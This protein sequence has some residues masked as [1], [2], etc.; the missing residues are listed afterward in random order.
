MDM[1]QGDQGSLRQ[2]Q[3]SARR[4]A[5]IGGGAAGL[6]ASWLLAQS[7]EVVLYEGAGRAGGHANTVIAE[8][9]DGEIAV[10]T[11]FIVYNERNYPNL[12]ALFDRL[13]VATQASEMSFAVSLD[14]GRTEYSGTDLNGLFARRANLVSPRFWS[15][16]ASLV[17]FYRAA[18]A[19]GALDDAASGTIGAYLHANGYSDAFINDHLLPM[20]GAIWSATPGEVLSFPLATFV[21]FFDSHGLL[22]LTD[23]PQWRTVTGGSINYVN[24]ITQLLGDGVR[25]HSAVTQV[26][27]SGADLLVTDAGG[28]SDV[29]TD[30]VFAGHPDDMLGLL[31][32][33]DSDQ[34]AI[35]GAFTYSDNH[36]VLHADSAL[37]PHRKRAWASWNYLGEGRKG[38]GAGQ[39]APEAGGLCVTY[40]MNRLQ[41]LPGSNLFVTL[42]P[43]ETAPL[44]QFY[45]SY[46]YRHPIFDH[47]ALAAQ[48]R[49]WDIQGRG[50]LWFCG[51]WCGY[52]FH[53][54][55]VQ[56]GL[57]VAEDIA[58]KQRPWSFN[59]AEERI[60]RTDRA[61]RLA[62]RA[63]AA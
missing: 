13:G 9:P 51:A 23:R 3:D 6:S 18:P 62:A 40:W 30:V 7:C 49:L 8:R 15:M 32:E 46:H 61:G 60:Y 44:Q 10:D 33:P 24:R 63:Q 28:N 48:K 26:R 43:S 5:V 37:M 39:G 19:A 36:A 35:L 54:D 41:G 1:K 47:A 56:S 25:T 29:F 31:A 11:G 17:R 16:L 52:G 22:S 2:N 59:R 12:I 42:N 55:A 34:A 27:L 20:A 53:E 4:V 38:G 50:G 57:A 45:A 58:G 14:G 21:R